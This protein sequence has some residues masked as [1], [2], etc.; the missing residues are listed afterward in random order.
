LAGLA[1]AAIAIA[2]PRAHELERTLVSLSFARDGAFTLEVSNDPHW[3]LMRLEPFVADDFPALLE[4]SPRFRRSAAERDVRLAALA[5]VF[6]DRIVLF[7]DGREVRPTRAEYLPPGHAQ[8]AMLRPSADASPS[9]TAPGESRSSATSVALE[10]APSSA[11]LATYR[12][13]GHL[14]SDAHTLRWFYG[15][16]S[17]P[18]PLTIQRSDGQTSTEWI[19]GQAWSD[20]IDLTGQFVPPTRWQIAHQ[21]LELGYVHILPRGLDH[22]LFVLGLFLLS[23]TFKPVLLQV[24]A[25]TIAHSITLGLSMY[26]VVSLPARIV[27]PLIAIS[28]AYVALENLFTREIRP[29]RLGLV[30]LFGLLHGLGF[31]GVLKDLGLPRGEFLTALVSFNLGVEA[32]Q[33]TVIAGATAVVAAA[34][35]RNWYRHVVVVPASLSIAAIGVYWTIVRIWPN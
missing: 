23:A 10:P 27:E 35:G 16:V 6:I 8:P 5:P 12:L 3:L 2:T 30:F 20:V 32:G 4:P 14:R 28:I 13:H 17:D 1:A 15:I 34:L 18:Y 22:I 24:T 7:V 19:A 33:L 25:F 31:A 29:W 9:T 11:V 26:D 21:Y